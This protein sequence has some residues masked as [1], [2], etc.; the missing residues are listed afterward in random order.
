MAVAPDV[1]QRIWWLLTLSGVVTF[2]VGLVWLLRE[3][4]R[5]SFG[6]ADSVGR[7]SADE[8]EGEDV[9]ESTAV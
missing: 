2:L 4:L 1:P 6:D 3:K 5:S 8:D 7:S 9:S